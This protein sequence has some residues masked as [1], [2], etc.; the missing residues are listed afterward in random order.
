MT[1]DYKGKGKI[2]V[3]KSYIK[4]KFLFRLLINKN[5]APAYENNFIEQFGYGDVHTNMSNN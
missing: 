4:H 5:T 1:A 3:L 2:S